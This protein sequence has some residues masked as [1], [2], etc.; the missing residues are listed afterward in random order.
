MAWLMH[1]DACGKPSHDEQPIG[2]F[3]VQVIQAESEPS[4]PDWM[5]ELGLAATAAHIR[6]RTS[7]AFC[8]AACL[9]TFAAIERE[10]AP[11]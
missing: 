4:V 5:V 9:I 10:E 3:F 6:K 7:W 2:W 11:S 8:S 1:C